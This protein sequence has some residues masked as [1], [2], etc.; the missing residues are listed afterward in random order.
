MLVL[1]NAC[2]IALAVWGNIHQKNFAMFLLAI[3]MSNLI[4]YTLFY[5][6]MKVC[7]YT[8]YLLDFF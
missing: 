7:I 5:I 2:N 1:A 8:F 6:V 4:L 3:L